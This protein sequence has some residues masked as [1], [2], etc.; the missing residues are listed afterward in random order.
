M[1]E[2][3]S[4]GGSYHTISQDH[5]ANASLDIELDLTNGSDNPAWQT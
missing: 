1:S 5:A 3:E 4:K 2:V